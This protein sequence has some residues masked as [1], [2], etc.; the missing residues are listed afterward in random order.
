MASNISN[1]V[2]STKSTTMEEE[3]DAIYYEV[4]NIKGKMGASPVAAMRRELL[5]SFLAGLESLTDDVGSCLRLFNSWKRKHKAN[6]D[7]DLKKEVKESVEEMQTAFN[8]YREGIADKKMQLQPDPAPVVGMPGTVYFDQLLQHLQSDSK[9]STQL[10]FN[11]QE[12]QMQGAMEEL[13]GEVAVANWELARDDAIKKA[14]LKVEGWRARKLEVGKHFL[15][16]KAWFKTHHADLMDD[17]QSSY[18]K[19]KKRVENFSDKFEE[20]V[21]ELEG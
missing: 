7:A 1:S 4:D 15:T 10:Q 21:A 3:A 8:T 5:E 14:R 19:I 12:V 20:I 17:P 9:T 13:H 18:R 16:Y 2:V 11:E 6:P